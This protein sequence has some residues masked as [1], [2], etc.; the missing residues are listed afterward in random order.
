MFIACTDLVPSPNVLLIAVNVDTLSNV[1]GL[2]LQGH[3]DIA[4]LIIESCAGNRR[5]QIKHNSVN[6]KKKKKVFYS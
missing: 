6:T 3:Q 5:Q 1:R 4:G 2:L